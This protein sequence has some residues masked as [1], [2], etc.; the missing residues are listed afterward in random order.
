MNVPADT[1]IDTILKKE[2][3]ES[4]TQVSLIASVIR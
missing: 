4:A 3:L 1:G 2:S